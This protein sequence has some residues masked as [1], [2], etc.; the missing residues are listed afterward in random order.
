MKKLYIILIALAL[1]VAMIV[2]MAT[3]AAAATHKAEPAKPVS[4]VS[5]VFNEKMHL[6][7]FNYTSSSIGKVTKLSEGTTVGHIE[8]HD[9]Y[10]PGTPFNPGTSIVKATYTDDTFISSDF[11]DNVATFKCYSYCKET[12]ETSILWW[13][14]IDNGEPGRYKDKVMVSVYFPG[15]WGDWWPLCGPQDPSDPSFGV[16]VKI[17]NGD[18]DVHVGKEGFPKDHH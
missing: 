7:D 16:P 9:I 13:Q 12:G 3:P 5:I 1:A 18:I 10:Y 14:L 15:P 6:P 8:S 17:T 2:P 11:H 4:W